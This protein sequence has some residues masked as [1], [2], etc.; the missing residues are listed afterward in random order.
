MLPMGARAYICFRST[1]EILG[2][3]PSEGELRDLDVVIGMLPSGHPLSALAIRAKDFREPDA[4][5]DSLLHPQD[6]AYTVPE[7]HRWLESAGMVFGRWFEQAPYS[8]QCG[9]AANMPHGSRL[10]SLPA[11]LQHAAVE[12]LRGTMTTHSFIAYRDD[13]PDEP[14]PIG[15]AGEAWRHYIPLRLPW[16]ICIRDRVPPGFATVLI[17]RA[18]THADLALPIDAAEERFYLA[19][20]GSRSNGEICRDVA[21]A[22]DEEQARKLFQRLW[23]N[24]Q[25]VF[26]ATGR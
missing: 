14:Q 16:T 19:I 13:Y 25:I 3:R 12:L 17:N 8:P 23:E 22:G 15:F 20:D 5:A 4:L 2:I 18:H 10:A 21:E 11:K 9:I 24:D 1:A 6:R 7:L 26:D